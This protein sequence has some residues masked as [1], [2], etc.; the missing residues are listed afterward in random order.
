M[1][2]EQCFEYLDAPIRRVGS[3]ETPVPFAKTL[4]ETYLPK[5]RFEEALLELKAY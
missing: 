3:L 2:A 5:E 4:E 1:I